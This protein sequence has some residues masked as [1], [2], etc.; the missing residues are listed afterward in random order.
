[1]EEDLNSLQP[2]GLDGQ[3]NVGNNSTQHHIGVLRFYVF[4]TKFQRQD[5]SAMIS[6]F[7][8]DLLHSTGTWCPEEGQ[9]GPH[10]QQKVSQ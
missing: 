7:H 10:A 4:L 5:N 9:P 8:L 2:G 6:S 3:I 1:M